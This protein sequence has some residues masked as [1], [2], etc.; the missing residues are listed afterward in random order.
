MTHQ[1]AVPRLRMTGISKT[2]GSLR[3]LENAHFA[4]EAGE[5]MALLGENGAGKSTLVKVLAGVVIADGGSIEI[6]GKPVQIESSRD[7]QR[8]GVAVLQQE[9]SSVPCLSVAENLLLGDDRAAAWV[10]PRKERRTAV[11]LLKQVGLEH[12]DPETLVSDLSVAEVQ[13][14]ELARVLHRDARIIVF[15]EPTAALSD[16][17]I[18][19]VLTVA[20]RLADEG[21]SIIYVTHRLPEV[22]QI[23]DRVTVF[24]SGHSTPPQAVGDLTV[25]K[26]I[27][28]M[29]GRRLETLY[30]DRAT[31]LSERDE[32]LAVH[33]LRAPGLDRPTSLT[34]RPG[35]IL[36]LTGQ[37][38]SGAASV[39]RAIAGA[40]PIE[41]GTVT[42]DGAQVRV[43]S[44]RRANALGIAFCSED[45]KHDGM[46]Q[47]ADV[48]SNLS[49]PWLTS[50]TSMGWVVRRSE[51]SRAAEICRSFAISTGRLGT[52]VEQLSGGNQQKVVLGRW[53]GIEPRVLLVEEPT[54]GVDVGARAELYDTLRQ[55]AA[56]GTAVVVSS[57]DTSEILGLC[58]TIAAFYKG[59]LE[60][61]A[62]HDDWDAE[63]LAAAVMHRVE[64]VS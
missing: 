46:F 42:L 14:L 22:F 12:V 57:S 59:R 63:R 10:A 54:R 7:S 29:I 50:T 9:Y 64:A 33:D 5:I 26:V 2:Y 36:G 35:E 32:R 18:D 11:G 27:Q 30:P 21:R 61:V 49:A 38:G 58:D 1:Q 51:R 40:L 20:R 28:Q 19:R 41:S 62:S 60:R 16:V 55:L 6:D 15:D 34:V 31:G 37:L 47:G 44:R 17:E 43:G 3:A 24:N 4:L 53:L 13:L 25:E 39:I 45:R 56:R 52:R 23:A 8:A 48:L